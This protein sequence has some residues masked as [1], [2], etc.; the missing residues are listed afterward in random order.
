MPGD[1]QLLGDLDD[2]EEHD[3]QEGHDDQGGEQ[4]RG[5]D[6]AV[7]LKDDVAESFVGA[8]EFA[9]HGAGDGER[10]S[11]LQAGHELWQRG[12]EPDLHEGLETARTHRRGEFEDL[13]IHR[14]QT[15][16]ARDDDREEGHQDGDEDLGRGA[17]AEPHDEQWRD[18]DLGYHLCEEDQRV[19]RLLHVGG[20][21][22]HDGHQ[23]AEDGGDREAD[24]RL[25][26]GH[27]G[28][29]GQVGGVLPGGGPR[30]GR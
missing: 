8:D 14:P 15:C 30:I 28:V 27:P 18:R 22:H 20:V 21:H 29:L 12:R 3:A 13:G 24:H 23:D 9:N 16:E 10:G 6:V 19:D 11:D 25:P 1:E 2:G 7:R 5:V 17:E 26:G 4:H